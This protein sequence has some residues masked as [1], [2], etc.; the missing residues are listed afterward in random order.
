MPYH[1]L[2][3]AEENE[4]LV[5]D[6]V[7]VYPS[8]SLFILSTWDYYWLLCFSLWFRKKSPTDLNVKWISVPFIQLLLPLS[9]SSY[10]VSSCSL[11]TSIC[12][13]LLSD[14]SMKWS[15]LCTHFRGRFETNFVLVKIQLSQVLFCSWI[16]VRFR[17]HARPVIRLQMINE[18]ADPLHGLP[19][20]NT[21]TPTVKAKRKQV[22]ITLSDS[23]LIQEHKVSPWKKFFSD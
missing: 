9:L 14:T 7:N 21:H 17:A 4:D 5:E 12:S 3:E 10:L 6:E 18:P 13:Q 2:A 20:P 23:P 1:L 22:L 16:F 8:V 15:K 11:S 19:E